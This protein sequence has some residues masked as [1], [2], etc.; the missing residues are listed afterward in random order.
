MAVEKP[1]RHKSA[2]TDQITEKLF[3]GR[4]R[5]IPAEIHN[6]FVLCG[7]RRNFMS[8]GRNQEFNFFIRR[9]IKQMVVIIEAYHSYQLR[10]K[11][12]PSYFC[13]S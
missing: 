6:F 3:K 9:V 7:I 4:G 2:G 11:L 10:T 5:K 12:Y 1:E 13:R 8:S